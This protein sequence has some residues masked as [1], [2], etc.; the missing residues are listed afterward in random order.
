[1]NPTT[2][3]VE[4]K[5]GNNIYKDVTIDFDEEVV[6]F[7]GRLFSLTNV[8][9]DRQKCMTLFSHHFLKLITHSDAKRRSA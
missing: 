5:W 9:P 4:I 8:P 7:K 6:D 3:T 1:M 2:V